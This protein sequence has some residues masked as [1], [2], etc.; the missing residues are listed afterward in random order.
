LSA[1]RDCLFNIFAVYLPTSGGRLLYPHPKD[2]SRDYDK[3]HTV[4]QKKF[5]VTNYLETRQACTAV[6]LADDTASI[7]VNDIQ[8]ER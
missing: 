4:L 3:V 6:T 7:S 5:T 8:Q 1:V 2:A